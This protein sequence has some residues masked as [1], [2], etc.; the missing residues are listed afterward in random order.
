MG[1]CPRTVEP[2]S[3]YLKVPSVISIALIKGPFEQLDSQTHGTV[4]LS[5]IVM[6]SVISVHKSV[7]ITSFPHENDGKSLD[8]TEPQ[9]QLRV[10][11]PFKLTQAA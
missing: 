11:S 7:T 8:F 10:L 1:M 2:D 3:K 4:A 6:V 5:V 9:E